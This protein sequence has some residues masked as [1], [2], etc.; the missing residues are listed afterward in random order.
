MSTH[1]GWT[2]AKVDG[3]P[4]DSAAKLRSDL[5]SQSMSADA[6]QRRDAFALLRMLDGRKDG[7][8]SVEDRAKDAADFLH[9]G[10]SQDV[11]GRAFA[12]AVELYGSVKEAKRRGYRDPSEATA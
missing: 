6:G 11:R 2:Q 7:A 12:A 1:V 5:A 9:P 4:A 3:L 8:R 10:K